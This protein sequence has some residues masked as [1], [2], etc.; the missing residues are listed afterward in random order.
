[1]KEEKDKKGKREKKQEKHRRLQG[2]LETLSPFCSFS[3]TKDPKPQYF[4][5]SSSSPPIQKRRNSSLLCLQP[6]VS[7]CRRTFLRDNIL[8]YREFN[9]KCII[10]WRTQTVIFFFEFIKNNA[11]LNKGVLLVCSKATIV[12]AW[13]EVVACYLS[14]AAARSL[15]SNLG[16]NS[17]FRC[18]I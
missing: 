11:Q 3:H 12:G 13:F 10:L 2:S 15:H 7:P 9:R 14:F 4:K 17:S 16:C 8:I 1:M 5:V 6:L 18:T